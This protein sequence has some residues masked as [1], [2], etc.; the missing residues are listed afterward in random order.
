[1][2][3]QL[4]NDK[5]SNIVEYRTDL[6]NACEF[7]EQADYIILGTPFRLEKGILLSRSSALD[8]YFRRCKAS[9]VIYLH[10]QSISNLDKKLIHICI[11]ERIEL[12]YNLCSKW[13]LPAQNG[14]G[15]LY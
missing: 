1:M 13:P 11:A 6:I 3:A 12:A 9:D 5:I 8:I 2:S 10:E 4:L 7:A 15:I 14:L